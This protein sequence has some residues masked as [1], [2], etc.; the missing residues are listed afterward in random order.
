MCDENTIDLN[1]NNFQQRNFSE[2]IFTQQSHK[3]CR[4]QISSIFS[5]YTIT[6]YGVQPIIDDFCIHNFLPYEVIFVFTPLHICF[7][8]I[9]VRTIYFLPLG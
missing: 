4:I 3:I 6:K 2:I 9:G 7:K 1:G 5:G 8:P